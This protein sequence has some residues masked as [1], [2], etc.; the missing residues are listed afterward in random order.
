MSPYAASEWDC[1]T[2]SMRE[3]H[4]GEELSRFIC[5]TY[6]NS[7]GNFLIS[8]NTQSLGNMKAVI[9]AEWGVGLNKGPE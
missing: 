9:S 7:K 8:N 5:E 4:L 2:A 1:L 6:F 3:S